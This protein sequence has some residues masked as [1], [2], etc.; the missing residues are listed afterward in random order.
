MKTTILANGMLQ[1]TPESDLEAYAL[2]MWAEDNLVG[3]AQADIP[4]MII[5][6]SQYADQMSSLLR[7]RRS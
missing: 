3:R 6:C 1:V 2:H 5:D 4:S 7:R